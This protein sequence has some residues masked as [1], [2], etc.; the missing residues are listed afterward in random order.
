MIVPTWSPQA[1]ADLRAFLRY[2]RTHNPKAADAAF[3]ELFASANHFVSHPGM[4][5]PGG[6]AG[7]REFSV[8]RWH[9]ILVYRVDATGI[10]IL[11]VRDTRMNSNS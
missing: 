2:L 4:G 10:E 5:R 11:T 9:K 8:T 1:R 7:T 6:L 3:A